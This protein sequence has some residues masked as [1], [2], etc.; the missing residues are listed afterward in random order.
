[1]SLALP[2]WLVGDFGAIVPVP[3]RA[4]DDGRHDLSVRSPVASQLVGDQPPGLTPLTLQ[5]LADKAFGSPAVATR[6]DEDVDDVAILIDGTPEIVPLSLDGDEDLVQV[7]C[8]AQPAL[9]TLEP[10]SVFRAELDAPKPDCFVGHRDAA[11]G[12]EI[13]YIAKAHT[14][15]MVQPYGVADDLGRESISMVARR[16]AFHRPSL[17]LS[18]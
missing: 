9:S 17:P 15:S 16:V 6:L 4:I 11:L 8:V 14:E 13:F 7:L 3:F 5:Q 12:Q 1:M 18:R 2:C 10:A